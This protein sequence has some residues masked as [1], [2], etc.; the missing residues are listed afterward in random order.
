[1][2]DYSSLPWITLTTDYGHRGPYVG[3]LKGRILSPTGH[4]PAWWISPTTSRPRILLPP[5]VL[6]A[7]STP[8][9]PPGTIHVVVV[10]LGVG[11]ER[12]LLYAEIGSC[13]YL[14]P[15][16]GV[17]TLV[18]K[19][20]CGTC[21]GW[22]NPVFAARR[23]RPPFT[24]AIFC[25]W[26]H[27]LPRGWIRPSWGPMRPAPSFGLAA[28]PLPARANCRASHLRGQLG[29]PHHQHPPR[30]FAPLGPARGLRPDGNPAF[31]PQNPR[32]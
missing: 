20:R 1:M 12:A 22:P 17:L 13:R 8:Y 32:Y 18:Y 4:R 31:R 24:A 16:N 19:I 14:A 23:Y 7:D 29:K 11:T 15:D 25:R 27:S 21:F 30:G 28:A 5:L 3:A 10:D 6:A 26:Q 2:A 9:F